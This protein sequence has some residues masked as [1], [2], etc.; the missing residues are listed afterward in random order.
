MSTFNRM[1][2]VDGR[3]F[4][5]EAM[6]GNAYQVFEIDQSEGSVLSSTFCFCW[7]EV[8]RLV[9]KSPDP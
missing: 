3:R 4:D 1:F 6:N 5:V 7:T 2:V 9:G 8:L